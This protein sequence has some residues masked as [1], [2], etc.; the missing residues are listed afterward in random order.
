M[1]E[2]LIPYAHEWRASTS[3]RLNLKLK[4]VL[5]RTG[6]KVSGRSILAHFI[7]SI[8]SWFYSQLSNV[9]VSDSNLWYMYRS[10]PGKHPLPGKCPCT[11]L[12]GVIVAASIWIRTC[13]PGKC[14]CGPKS[15]LMFKRL[16][17][18]LRYTCNYM[19]THHLWGCSPFLLCDTVHI[20][21]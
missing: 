1:R 17:G 13:I 18:I 3:V 11:I 8:H 5:T 4:D 16:W 10:V 6:Y 21:A 19:Y 15:W 20:F 7:M 9:Y 2:T 12:H 14:P